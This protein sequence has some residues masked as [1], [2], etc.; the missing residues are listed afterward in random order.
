MH[1]IIPRPWNNGKAMPHWGASKTGA[2]S[3]CTFLMSVY[4]MEYQGR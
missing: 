4:T 2:I 3:L 1:N